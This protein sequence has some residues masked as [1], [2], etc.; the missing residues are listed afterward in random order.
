M[1]SKGLMVVGKD[2]IMFGWLFGNNNY[3]I[4][5]CWRFN[6]YRQIVTLISYLT[7]K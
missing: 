4:L 6:Y 2:K 7:S 1:G 5:G 3:S